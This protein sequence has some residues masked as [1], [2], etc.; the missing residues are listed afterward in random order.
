MS[1]AV[2]ERLRMLLGPE[3]VERDPPGFPRAVPESD[4]A[5]A[6]VCQ[7]AQDAGWHCRV[8]GSASWLTSGCA[9]RPGPEHARASINWSRSSAADLV[10]TVEAG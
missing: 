1:D 6:L 10:A 8:E 4:D 9:G 5:M 2:F 3:G 7:A